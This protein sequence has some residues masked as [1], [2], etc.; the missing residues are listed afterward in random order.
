LPSDLLTFIHASSRFGWN[1]RSASRLY[2]ADAS[3][4][5]TPK[6]ADF[7]LAFEE[8]SNEKRANTKLGPR[9]VALSTRFSGRRSS[10]GQPSDRKAI[11]LGAIRLPSLDLSG[12]KQPDLDSYRWPA[13]ECGSEGLLAPSSQG[14]SRRRCSRFLSSSRDS[15]SVSSSLR[16]RKT[17]EGASVIISAV[18]KSVS[19]PSCRH[20]NVRVPSLP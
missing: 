14:I 16:S 13:L 15:S 7:D 17:R 8:K 3:Q 10:L 2:G 1:Q 12:R 18:I 4:Y 6:P 19:R 9:N 20:V 11:R 5:W